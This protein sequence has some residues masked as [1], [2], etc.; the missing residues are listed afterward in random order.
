MTQ[1]YLR[2][3]KTILSSFKMIITSNI[4]DEKKKK[5]KKLN[6]KEFVGNYDDE[7]EVDERKVRVAKGKGG[8]RKKGLIMEK[9][10]ENFPISELILFFFCL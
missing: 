4:R 5:G 10:F 2:V 3:E 6:F 8:A 9:G 1:L 7:N